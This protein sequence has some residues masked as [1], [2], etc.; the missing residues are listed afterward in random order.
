L[1][2][3]GYAVIEASNGQAA[4]IAF[5]THAEIDLIFTDIAMPGI[6][7][8]KVADCAKIRRP[9]VKI[10]Y[11][12]AYV[13]RAAEH[14]GIIH[15]PVLLKPYRGKQLLAAVKQEL[16]PSRHGNPIGLD[17]AIRS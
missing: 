6:D 8:F 4:M 3:A 12:T 9:A 5:E 15:G 10:L 7:G 16:A 2:E 14:L 11:T 17:T 13:G 1:R